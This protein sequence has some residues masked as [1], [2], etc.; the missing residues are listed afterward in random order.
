MDFLGQFLIKFLKR[1]FSISLRVF[2]QILKQV[3]EIQNQNHYLFQSFGKS[4]EN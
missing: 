2:K 1:K 4:N 3:L